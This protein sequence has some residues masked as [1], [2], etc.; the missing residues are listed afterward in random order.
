MQFFIIITLLI[1]AG[2][3]ALFTIKNSD[4]LLIATFCAVIVGFIFAISR[5]AKEK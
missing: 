5:I 3:A 2:V 4:A 1:S